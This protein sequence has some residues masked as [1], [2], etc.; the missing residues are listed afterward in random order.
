MLRGHIIFPWV[1]KMQSDGAA[2]AWAEV[3]HFDLVTCRGSVDLLL[4]LVEECSPHQSSQ[5]ATPLTRPAV[6]ETA[7]AAE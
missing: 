1:G 4:Q 3:R 2:T 5:P 7:V 6:P